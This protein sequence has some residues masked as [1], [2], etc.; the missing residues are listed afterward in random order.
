M[1]RNKNIPASNTKEEF[2]PSLEESSS[3]PGVAKA[4]V[5]QKKQYGDEV[6]QG[7]VSHIHELQKIKM[8]LVAPVSTSKS[9]ATTVADMATDEGPAKV[10]RC[11][12]TTL[13]KKAEELKQD[14]ELH[15]VYPAE[16]TSITYQTSKPHKATSIPPAA[17]AGI[18]TELKSHIWAGLQDIDRLKAA[19]DK[20]IAQEKAGYKRSRSSASKDDTSRNLPNFVAAQFCFVVS[21]G[22]HGK[23]T[24]YDYVTVPVV[25]TNDGDFFV[26]RD[27][28]FA[29][30][31][32]F[33]DEVIRQHVNGSKVATRD[34][35]A[36]LKK[37]IPHLS[38]TEA[39]HEQ[40]SL[41]KKF[42]NAHKGKFLSKEMLLNAVPM[43]DL[44]ALYRYEME[45]AT[46][47]WE[48]NS[49]SER[50]FFHAIQSDVAIEN[51]YNELIQ[52]LRDKGY[53]SDAMDEEPCKLYS[54]VAFINSYPNTVCGN[55]AISVLDFQ[56]SHTNGGFADKLMKRFNQAG[57]GLKTRGY[58]DTSKHAKDPT[59]FRVL[60]YVGTTKPFKSEPAMV[61]YENADARV[62]LPV[63]G[64]A[65]LHSYPTQSHF[66]EQYVSGDVSERATQ[67][68]R[69]PLPK[70]PTTIAMSGQKYTRMAVNIER[71][72]ITK[73]QKRFD[74]HWLNLL[75]NASG[76]GKE[77]IQ[78]LPREL[79]K[80]LC[81]HEAFEAIEE[82]LIDLYDLLE[83]SCDEL[84]ILLGDQNDKLLK[85]FT[86]PDLF[87]LFTD[88]R[89]LY[90]F[91]SS[92]NVLMYVN[93]WEQLNEVLELANKDFDLAQEFFDD[94]MIEH[95]MYHGIKSVYKKYCELKAN[96]HN[97]T[98]ADAD[99]ASI[100]DSGFYCP[101]EEEE[102]FTLIEELIMHLR[103][104]QYQEELY[105]DMVSP[106]HNVVNCSGT[107]VAHEYG[108]SH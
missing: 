108:P 68:Q 64:G 40:V 23:H 55:C 20:E 73:R 2:G 56:N 99:S 90:N 32:A 91:L 1:S 92:D 54:M 87:E 67:L 7:D 27:E 21:N 58:D 70:N 85:E 81:N 18:L 42:L 77:Y 80:Q 98:N 33:K 71:T 47:F 19:H 102:P 78:V 96:Q 13:S 104:V 4:L 93:E 72:I 17:I 61:A 94:D 6:S 62:K 39:S 29:S 76:I 49:H 9:N 52:A 57:S 38:K 95:L 48:H 60:G 65:N 12:A 30:D 66:L 14:I 31:T 46:M 53:L 59:R 88:R 25:L 103:K 51:L 37:Y 28:E 35:T 16:G 41:I 69:T 50:S 3:L 45:N 10:T 74:D 34:H 97:R 84:V 43:I 24:K 75:V 15:K 5:R 8:K 100:D 11:K 79:Q 26:S 89:K 82:G 36:M 22:P 106:S 86:F 63:T 101:D 83:L 44:D 105:S 107:M